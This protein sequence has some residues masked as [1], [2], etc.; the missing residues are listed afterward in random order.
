MESSHLAAPAGAR[1]PLAPAPKRACCGAAAPA[2]PPG[3]RGRRPAP[4]RRMWGARAARG[5]TPQPTAFVSGAGPALP[6][7]V[8]QKR[9]GRGTRVEPPSLPALLRLAQAAAWALPRA[10]PAARSRGRPGASPTRSR[11]LPP[12]PGAAKPRPPRGAAMAGAGR[13]AASVIR[14]GG[15]HPRTRARTRGLCALSPSGAIGRLSKPSPGQYPLSLF[16]S[17]PSR[18]GSRPPARPPMPCARARAARLPRPLSAGAQGAPP[19][20]GPRRG[21]PRAASTAPPASPQVTSITNLTPGTQAARF[22]QAP[23]FACTGASRQELC[24]RVTRRDGCVPVSVSV[25]RLRQPNAALEGGPPDTYR[26]PKAACAGTPPSAAHGRQTARRRR[27]GRAAQRLPR[28][29]PISFFATPLLQ[30]CTVS[31]QPLQKTNGQKQRCNSDGRPPAVRVLAP[32]AKETVRPALRRTTHTWG[33]QGRHN[34]LLNSVPPRAL[35]CL[36]IN[37]AYSAAGRA[38]RRTPATRLRSP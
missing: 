8:T 25:V 6:A 19:A 34:G 12:R 3:A 1:A 11:R 9:G 16:V 5:R 21:R 18:T 2:R 29:I 10:P 28:R 24:G 20:R 37:S 26:P 38:Q 13:A 17:A 14:C 35:P 15:A 23:L 33:R 36:L 22:P 7:A 32:H 4:R 27:W 31:V 30:R